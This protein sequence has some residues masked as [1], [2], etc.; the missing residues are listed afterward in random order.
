MNQTEAIDVF[1][2]INKKGLYLK[3][4]ERVK[5]QYFI[6]IKLLVFQ[7]LKIFW[8]QMSGLKIMSCHVILKLLT[9]S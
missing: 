1:L 8:K 5:Y 4:T 6:V 3:Y 9:N 7:C 2:P